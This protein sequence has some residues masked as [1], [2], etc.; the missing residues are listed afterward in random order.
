[1]AQG[2]VA[3]GAQAGLAERRA[4]DRFRGDLADRR[5]TEVDA[6]HGQEIRGN[7]R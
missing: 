2:K 6:R 5:G 7:N 1:M 3:G 4:A